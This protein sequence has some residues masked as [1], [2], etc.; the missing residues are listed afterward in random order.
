MLEAY[1]EL[2]LSKKSPSES[3]SLLVSELDVSEETVSSEEDD[4]ESSL[5]D[6]DS[7]CEHFPQQP[8][9]HIYC[10]L[11]ELEQ[12]KKLTQQQSLDFLTTFH[13]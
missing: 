1:Q 10:K 8:S 13:Q 12:K 7:S 3:C 11:V 5:E 6:S 4:S 9:W 2:R